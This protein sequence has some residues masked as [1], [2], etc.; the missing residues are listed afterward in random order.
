MN[1]IKNNFKI[2]KGNSMNKNNSCQMN[3]VNI[4]IVIINLYYLWQELKLIKL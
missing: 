4:K 2:N 1:G 3:S